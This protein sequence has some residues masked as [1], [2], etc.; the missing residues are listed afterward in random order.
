MPQKHVDPVDPDPEN[1]LQVD[2]VSYVGSI[3]SVQKVLFPTRGFFKKEK[4]CKN[5][6]SYENDTVPGL[7]KGRKQQ[8]NKKRRPIFQKRMRFPVPHI[9]RP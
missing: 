5:K 8:L 9:K 3:E 7:S 4:I 1:C 2:A 6:I